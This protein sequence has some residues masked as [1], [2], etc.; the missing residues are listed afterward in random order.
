[1]ELWV[2][3]WQMVVAMVV[4]MV[5]ATVSPTG[6][7]ATLQPG[8]GVVLVLLVM[9]KLEGDGDL[10]KGLR[11]ADLCPVC[12]AVQVP[13]T[14]NIQGINHADSV[15]LWTLNCKPLPGRTQSAH[16]RA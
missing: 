4:V 1:M 9:D 11:T 7:L 12:F 14:T 3:R 8:G 2:V 16:Q 10:G 6:A 15:G 13:G 5:M